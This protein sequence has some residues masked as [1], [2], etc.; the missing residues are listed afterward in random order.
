MPRDHRHH[1][2]RGTERQGA[3]ITHKNLGRIGVEPEKTHA[4]TNEGPCENHYLS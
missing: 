1:T 3:N 4:R 2:E